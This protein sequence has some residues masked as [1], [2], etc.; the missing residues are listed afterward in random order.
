V[1]DIYPGIGSIA[2]LHS[3]LANSRTERTFVTA[4]DMPFVDQNIIRH[5][6]NLQQDEYD[7]V[8]PYSEGGQEPLHAVYNS[9]CKDVFECAITNGERKILDILP[10][11][12]TQLVT[13]EEMKVVD[14]SVEGFLNVNT[15]E[16][17]E[18][19]RD[20]R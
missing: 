2:G 16:E 8:I 13:W 5:L 1:P 11:M 10:R 6:C 14:G 20:I 3:A 15:P 17:Y 7:A 18:T 12:K 19:I 4:C 9:K